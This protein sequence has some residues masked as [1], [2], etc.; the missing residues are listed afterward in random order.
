MA[1]VVGRNS[2]LLGLSFSSL[3]FS[4]QAWV[5]KNLATLKVISLTLLRIVHPGWCFYDSVWLFACLYA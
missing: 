1:S 4:C 3:L 5:E 2:S